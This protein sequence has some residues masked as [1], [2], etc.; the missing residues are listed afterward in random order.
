MLMIKMLLTRILMIH[1]M[2]ITTMKV[3]FILSSLNMLWLQK[4][5]MRE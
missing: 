3:S 5:P 4:E 1:N 2:T